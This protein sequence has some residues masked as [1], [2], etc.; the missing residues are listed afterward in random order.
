MIKRKN[1]AFIVAFSI[2]LCLMLPGFTQG[3]INSGNLVYAQSLSSPTLSAET[4]PDQGLLAIEV[5]QA[6]AESPEPI[7][8]SVVAVY[9]FNNQNKKPVENNEP[10]AINDLI[11]VEINKFKSYYEQVLCNNETICNAKVALSLDNR[12]I[13][14]ILSEPVI[15]K[16]EQ[17]ILHFR[18]A[19]DKTNDEIWSDLIGSADPRTIFTPRTTDLSISPATGGN[20]TPI[21]KSHP[22]ALLRFR[23]I[24]MLFWTTMLL[25]A[26]TFILKWDVKRLLREDSLDEIA[27]ADR[28]YSLSRCQMLWWLFWVV[29]SYIF[30]YMA[31]GAID[32]IT[33]TVLSLMG[34][35][36]ATTLGA[37]LID[38]SD[39]SK[40]NNENKT[41]GFWQDLLNSKYQKGAGVHRLQLILWTMIL[42]VIFLVSVYTK[43]SM[44]Q[45]SLTLLALQ[46][47]SSGTY[48]GFKFPENNQNSMDKT[49]E[50]KAENPSLQKTDEDF[51]ADKSE[52]QKL[53]LD[54]NDEL[55]KKQ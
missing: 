20:G 11:V 43:L 31:T 52:P 49:V 2:M 7:M 30:I 45:F 27:M 8:P 39:N 21:A 54:S 14:G 13:P 9:K 35:G 23:W 3:S 37:V 10:V 36:S 44:P 5:A 42:T 15:F 25:L 26:L 22:V 4:L 12:R 33:E 40:P 53:A 6:Q 18:L 47:I 19:R 28:P 48:L 24:H 1:F 34:I 46:G 17:G 51:G 41:M 29:V 38:A 32:T 55:A 16:G 50:T